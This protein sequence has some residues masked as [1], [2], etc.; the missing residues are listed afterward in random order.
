M[1]SLHYSLVRQ[2]TIAGISEK[3]CYAI[4]FSVMVTAVGVG[5]WWTV[6]VGAILHGVCIV[7]TKIDEY[8]FEIILRTI[9]YPD[10]LE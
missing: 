7:C 5:V 6:I 2:I 1:V 9:K 3:T 8:F 10:Y 4:W